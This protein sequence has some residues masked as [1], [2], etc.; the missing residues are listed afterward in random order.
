LPTY[1][2]VRESPLQLATTFSLVLWTVLT[3]TAPIAMVFLL[4]A[5]DL[6]P[7]LYGPQWAPSVPILQILAG[8]SILRALLD[9]T[10]SILVGT[11]RSGQLA[12]LTL[13]QSV[14]MIALVLPMTWWFGTPGTAIAAGA[15]FLLSALFILHFGH[16][17]LKINLRDTV[18]LPVLNSLLTIAGYWL[19][20]TAWPLASLSPAARLALEVGLIVV[21]Y[22]CLSLATG[23]RLVAGRLVLIY[24]A[25][26][27]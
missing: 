19:I 22:A 15:T 27:R 12:R 17:Q 11:Q 8:F 10:R 16:T 3:L 21:L 24:N 2:Q 7:V 23:R 9:D 6:V 20:T 5:P 14:V 26:R 13:I 18:G 4:T 25:L 1:A